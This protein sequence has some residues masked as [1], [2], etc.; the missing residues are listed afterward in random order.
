MDFAGA[1]P[2]MATPFN[3]GGQV[4]P[5][6]LRQNIGRWIAGGVRGVVALGSNGEAPLLDEDWRR[7]KTV[8]G[9]GQVH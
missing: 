6:A 8:W 5:A 3:G 4:D 2:P 7:T 1:F 9:S